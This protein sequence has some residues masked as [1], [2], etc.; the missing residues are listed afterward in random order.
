MLSYAF[1]VGSSIY[2]SIAKREEKLQ[3]IEAFFDFDLHLANTSTIKSNYKYLHTKLIKLAAGFCC[4]YFTAHAV[5]LRNTFNAVDKSFVYSLQIFALNTVI[6]SDFF[7]T[8]VFMAA[9]Q[10]R[11]RTLSDI[12]KFLNFVKAMD[13]RIFKNLKQSVMKLFEIN[14]LLEKLLQSRLLLNLVEVNFSVL[15]CLYWIGKRILGA[16]YVS[17]FCKSFG[18]FEKK[19]KVTYT[20][21][22][23]Q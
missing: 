13:D 5:L 10:N 3:L 11:M 8:F 7:Q 20:R 18:Y 19:T 4:F 14:K 23:L 17:F 6:L 21:F 12:F 1:A 9:I 16:H 22:H 2:V 15:C